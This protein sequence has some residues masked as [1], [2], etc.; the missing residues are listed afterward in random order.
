MKRLP[1]LFATLA[2]IT[3]SAAAQAGAKAPTIAVLDFNNSA[4]T[5][6]AA[7][8]EP[9]RAGISDMLLTE[10]SR[11][12]G[13]VLVERATIMKLLAEQDLAKSGRVDP[14]T[15]ARLGKILG[16]QYIVTGG[17][18]IDRKERLRLDARAVNVETSEV[19]YV[20]TVSGAADDLLDLTVKLAGAMNKGMRLPALPGAS[21]ATESSAPQKGRLQS[22]LL[23]STALIE[24]GRNPVKAKELYTQF[25]KASPTNFALAQRSKAEA[26]I[27]ALGG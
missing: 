6:D 5:A 17:F 23:Y 26:R 4:L 14:A 7:R 24:E 11:N 27:R 1:V 10:L 25:L 21:K 19:A 9:F 8:Y 2:G 18:V 16:A 15:A 3:S 13:I 22:L 12:Q 20:E